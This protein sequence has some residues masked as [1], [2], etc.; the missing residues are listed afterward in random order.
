MMPLSSSGCFYTQTRY[1]ADGLPPFVPRSLQNP[2]YRGWQLSLMCCEPPCPLRLAT[3]RRQ[4]EWRT[5]EYR[6]E[7]E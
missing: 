7:S 1:G 3:L 2:R 5:A 6:S 4:S